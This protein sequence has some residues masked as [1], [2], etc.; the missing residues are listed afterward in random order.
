MSSYR[1]LFR[2]KRLMNL[3][4]ANRGMT[5]TGKQPI[6]DVETRKDFEQRVI[7]SDRPVV[8]DFHA[9]WCCPCKALAPRLENVVSEQ[10]G[11]VR[12][13]RVDIDE[14]GELAL[15][16]NVGSVPSLV[17]I[18]NGKVVNRMVGLQTSEYLRKW[19]LK[20]VPHPPPEDTEN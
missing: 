7:N 1:R 15:D 6:F 4:K 9:S 10:E 18:S 19:L 8:V 14:H 20:A 13:A 3:M 16:Y 11:R 2:A 12:L 5:S 17:V